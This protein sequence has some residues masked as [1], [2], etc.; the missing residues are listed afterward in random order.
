[1]TKIEREFGEWFNGL[2]IKNFSLS[3]VK[4]YFK[5]SRNT[6]PPKKYW[7]NI[8]RPIQIVDM[9]RDSLG[10]PITI[11]SSYRS[12]SYNRKVG[13]ARSSY[14]MQFMALDI[15][16]SKAS[17]T[18]IYN[19]LKSWRDVG[20]FKGGLKKYSSFVHIDTRGRNTTW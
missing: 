13:G 20:L 8:I 18:R 15:Q 14:H 19:K 4:R 5:R 3:E 17:P 2:G 6:F 10:V 16:S 9:L 7:K 11:T 1:M 12:P